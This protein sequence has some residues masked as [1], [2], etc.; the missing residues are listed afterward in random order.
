MCPL[1]VYKKGRESPYPKK[2]SLFL[3]FRKETSVLGM[4]CIIGDI[5]WRKGT[6]ESNNYFNNLKIR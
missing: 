3:M 5:I 1:G 2:E 4:V 6:K